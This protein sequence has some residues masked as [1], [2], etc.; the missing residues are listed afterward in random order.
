LTLTVVRPKAGSPAEIALRNKKM[1]SSNTAR[2][3][4]NVN[5][6]A[7]HQAF[8]AE[9]EEYLAALRKGVDEELRA[10]F[11]TKMDFIAEGKF[12]P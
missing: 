12:Q 6:T 10:N 9:L 4:R 8:V 11:R 2:P 3:K 1:L 5:R 7:F